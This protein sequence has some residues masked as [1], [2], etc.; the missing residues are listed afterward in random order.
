MQTNEVLKK[1]H[2]EKSLVV[3]SIIL[4]MI[5]FGSGGY[6]LFLILKEEISYVFGI[7]LVAII[8]AT[9]VISYVYAPMSVELSDRSLIL[10]RGFGKRIFKFSEIKDI[11][12]YI[13]NEAVVRICGIGGLFGY[14]G[15]Y[16]TKRMGNF[17][18]YVGDYS[19]TFFIERKDGKKYL[20][21][22]DDYDYIVSVVKKSVS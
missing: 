6:L 5:L 9:I 7:G 13:C 10:Y 1:V 8:F 12:I 2:K 18:S 19:Q 21:S 14:T 15:R 17:F 22:C 4:M 20:L 3:F 11:D 16:Y